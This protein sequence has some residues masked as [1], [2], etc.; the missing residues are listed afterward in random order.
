MS[1]APVARDIIE[2]F[3]RHGEW[4]EK[5]ADRL[6]GFGDIAMGAP[7]SEQTNIVERTRHKVG[8]EM[9]QYW[10]FVRLLPS[11]KS[12]STDTSFKSYGS[13][14]GATIA[15]MYPD[16]V[17]RASLDGVADSH[18]YMASGWTT[19]LQDTDLLGAKLAEYCYEGGPKNCALY[20]EDGPAVIAENLQRIIGKLR[21]EPIQMPGTSTMGPQ[22]ATY[23][24][25]KYLTRD[26][27]YQP[28]LY[29]PLTAQILYDLS[30][31]NGT[32]LI[33]WRLL[34]QRPLLNTPSKAC[35]EDGPYSRSC[36]PSNEFWDAGMGIACS[37]GGL[38]RINQTKEEYLA[39]AKENMAQ[40]QLLG[41]WWSS[42]QLPCT[43][44]K[45]QPHWRYE[46]DFHS[47]TAHPI[48]FVGNTIDPVTPFR[49][50]FTMAS[51]FE[52]AGIL[53]L[54]TEGHCSYATVSLC[55]GRAIREYFQTGKLPGK[56]GGLEDWDEWKGVGGLCGTDRVPFDGYKKG[57]YPVMPEGERDEEFWKALVELNQ[58]WP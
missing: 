3:E 5:E 11:P 44:W 52:G 38:S 12:S 33:A 10:G 45:A 34:E 35:H 50:A 32:S 14:L 25:L 53:H 58:V 28:L 18:D 49:N 20:D 55:A 57:E 23:N 21:K 19:N 8:E 22:V 39:Y 27:V 26:I 37:D 24:D 4:R 15:A 7:S 13:I 30:K 51:G 40:S 41:A 56:K 6:V 2:I 1:T 36:F 46:G 54:D 43:A 31:G 16:R 9:V 17:K 29:Y 48:L 47:T 42:I